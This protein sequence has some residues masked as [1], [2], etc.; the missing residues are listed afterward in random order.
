[1]PPAIEM[2]QKKLEKATSE[3]FEDFPPGAAK[4]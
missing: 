1:V 4:K 3:M 2:N